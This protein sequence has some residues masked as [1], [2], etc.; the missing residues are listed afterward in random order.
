MQKRHFT[1]IADVLKNNAASPELVRAMAD[2][3][4]STNPLFKRERFMDAATSDVANVARCADCAGI[5]HRTERAIE[6][7]KAIVAKPLI[8]ELA[9]MHAVELLRDAITNIHDD[10]DPQLTIR[11]LD[12]R[13]RR[14]RNAIEHLSRVS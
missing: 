3:L 9:N 10:N 11:H 7:H 14:L 6:R 5:L 12:A 13:A 8:D 4:A 2:A 1:L